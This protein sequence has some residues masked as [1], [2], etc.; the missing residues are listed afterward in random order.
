MQNYYPQSSLLMPSSPPPL[1]DSECYCVT[2]NRDRI[3]WG[4]KLMEL[5]IIF[6]IF[7]KAVI[8]IL[9]PRRRALN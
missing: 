3:G 9:R 5:K 6:H 7:V 1:T 8:D 4:R 2:Y